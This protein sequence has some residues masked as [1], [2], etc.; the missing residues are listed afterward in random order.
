MTTASIFTI[1]LSIIQD[2]FGRKKL[3]LYCFSLAFVG[4]LLGYFGN[5]FVVRLSGLMLLWSYMEVLSIAGVI[6]ANELLVN[7][8]RKYSMNIFS[9]TVCTG[10]VFGNFV[11]NYLDSF[12]PLILVIFLFYFFGFLMVMLLIPESPSYLLK[13]GKEQE[14]KTVILS[15]A[16][17]NNLGKEEIKKSMISLDSLIESILF[18]TFR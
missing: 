14:L 2:L 8:L 9:I 1:F 11:T 3:L 6:L 4:Y 17:T 5:S 16:K 13:Q 18:V 12:E 10:G 7:P 15:I